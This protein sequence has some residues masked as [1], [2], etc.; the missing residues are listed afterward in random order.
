M[1]HS[2]NQ[3]APHRTKLAAKITNAPAGQPALE[4]NGMISSGRAS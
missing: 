4:R 1:I 2:T 3:P